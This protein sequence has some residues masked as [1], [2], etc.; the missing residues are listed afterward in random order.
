M[1]A[2]ACS[3][4]VPRGV[5]ARRRVRGGRGP[6]RGPPS[7]RACRDRSGRSSRPAARPAGPARRRP[8]RPACPGPPRSARSWS[9]APTAPG[10][11]ARRRDPRWRRPARTWATSRAC[12]AC[13]AAARL[14]GGAGRDAA[15]QAPDPARQR[16]GDRRA[17]LVKGGH[18][19]VDRLRPG[20]ELRQPGAVTLGLRGVVPVV[21]GQVKPAEVDKGLRR[22]SS[23]SPYTTRARSSNAARWASSCASS[24]AAPELAASASAA[25][26]LRT[27]SGDRSWIVPSYSCRPLYSRASARS[28]SHTAR[29]RADRSF[30]GPDAIVPGRWCRRRT[31]GACPAL[32]APGRTTYTSSWLPSLAGSLAEHAWMS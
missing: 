9:S 24:R 32:P 14:G 10:R 18:R 21:A 28:R 16:G 20:G 30:M 15:G 2:I 26:L 29:S 8:P 23:S 11:P 1:N 22:Y 3:R 25:R 4:P 31:Y 19:G 13:A 12:A 5:E 6:V 7:G 17:D 27:P